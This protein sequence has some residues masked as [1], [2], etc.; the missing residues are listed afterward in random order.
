MTS[1][2]TDL[3]RLL[4]WYPPGWRERYGEE[5]VA[6]MEDELDS[7]PPTIA[8]RA[9]VAWSGLRER[10][11]GAGLPGDPGDAA[12]QA[13]AGSLVV[14]CSWT[15]FVLAGAS[16]AKLTEHFA[17]AMPMG[18]RS[19]A[20]LS[21]D[22]V[23]VLALTGAV[24][25]ATG[26][27]VALPSFTRFLKNRGGTRLRRKAAV[28]VGLSVLEVALVVP[29][30]IW[31]HHLSSVQRNGANV[32]YSVTF[33]GLALLAGGVLAQ[34]TA[35]AVTAA[36]H[37]DFARP[38]LRVE[39]TLAVVLATVMAAITGA[40]VIWWGSVG[41]AAPWFLQGTPEGTS[42]SPITLNLVLTVTLM[43]LATSSGLFG[44]Q[45]IARS[46]RALTAA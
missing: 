28:A 27:A 35:V 37:V 32:P 22:V 34:W 14:L 17:R 21:F 36:R 18:T 2:R 33:V 38:V 6:M 15:A 11:H 13:R 43:V 39:A 23:F 20:Q 12:L 29:F 4:A 26:V 24:V 45:R 16:Y 3:S 41:R 42:V 40:T 46:W 10:G 5:F 7:R 25:V 8:F 44:V 30:L 31:A 19:L 1:R 9:S